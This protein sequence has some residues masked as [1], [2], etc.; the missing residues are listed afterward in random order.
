MADRTSSDRKKASDVQIELDN[1]VLTIELTLIS[2]IQALALTFLAEY[3]RDVLV[4]LEFTFWPYAVSGLLI[5]LLFGPG[6]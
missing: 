4:D 5:I 1:L 3:S 6:L 2:I